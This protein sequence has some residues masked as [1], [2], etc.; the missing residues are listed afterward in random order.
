[1]PKEWYDRL[2]NRILEE[3][4]PEVI[5]RKELNL[6]IL[7]DKKPYFMRYIYP[8]LMKRYNT[9]I[10]NADKKCLREF[11]Q[12]I[13]EL[14]EKGIVGRSDA[15]NEFL[16]YYFQRMPIGMHTCVMNKICKRFENEFDNYFFKSVDENNFNYEVMKSGQDY[17]ATQYNAITKL[18]DQYTKNVQEFMQFSKQERMDKDE[19]A[20]ERHNMIHNFKLECEKISSN[21]SQLC[22]IILDLCYKCNSSKQFCWDMCGDEIINNLLG[23]NNNTIHFPVQDNNGDIE[24]CKKKFSIQCKEICK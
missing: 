2:S 6:R 4:T 22:D 18:Y 24:F 19:S 14:Q 11:R 9:Y 20:A 7:A 17:T 12:S 3:D 21:S 5:E 10:K 16:E 13:E 8:D 1:M 23:K 15:E